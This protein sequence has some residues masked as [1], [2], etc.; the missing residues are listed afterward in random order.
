MALAVA[1]QE[2]EVT[3]PGAAVA[4]CGRIADAVCSRSGDPLIERVCER[5]PR[6]EGRSREHCRPVPRPR[7]AR[8]SG[9]PVPQ[10]SPP[11]GLRKGAFHDVDL[12]SVPV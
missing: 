4:Q 8:A 2:K 5:V 10:T 11:F 6:A 12:L 7:A 9:G 3:S 1:E